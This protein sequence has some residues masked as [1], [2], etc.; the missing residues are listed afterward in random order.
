MAELDD[1]ATRTLD[2]GRVVEVFGS[3]A[4]RVYTPDGTRGVEFVIPVGIEL[5]GHLRAVP[6]TARLL[7]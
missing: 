2:D 5:T 6:L 4:V 1:P 7:D 3:G